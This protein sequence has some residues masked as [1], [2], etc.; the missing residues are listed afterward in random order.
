MIDVVLSVG[1]YRRAIR[2]FF[3]AGVA[4]VP[5]LTPIVALAF[6]ECIVAVIIAF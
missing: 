6:V 3:C 2:T 1:G 5:I 4:I